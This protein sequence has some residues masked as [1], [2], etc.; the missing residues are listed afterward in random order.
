MDICICDITELDCIRLLS[1]ANPERIGIS[2]E[3]ALA[4]DIGKVGDALTCYIRSLGA[5][6]GDIHVAV[7]SP[8]ARRRK[9]GISCHV[10]SGG[11][12]PPDFIDLGQGVCGVPSETLYIQLCRRLSFIKR[13][14]LA[15]ELAGRYTIIPN[16]RY[17]EAEAGGANQP[18]TLSLE[19]APLTTVDRLRRTAEGH[20]NMHGAK[21]AREALRY[22]VDNAC[23]PAEACMAIAMTLPHNK[24][25][26][27][28][29]PM[30]MNHRVD[31][32]GHFRRCDA[33]LLVGGI[34][35]EYGSRAHHGSIE[36]MES[37]SIR[38][39]ELSSRGV[40]VV[41]ISSIE[42]RNPRLFHIVMKRVYRLQGRRLRITVEDFEARRDRLW[43]ELF[44]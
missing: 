30:I 21:L 13:I 29:G 18:P 2:R 11:S 4:A 23:S 44:S 26:Y 27:A 28:C 34:D 38:A 41:N 40:P 36:A 35:M 6:D 24:G 7:P 42:L 32:D 10:V 19:R 43:H 9:R 25:G 14:R 15:C 17:G 31:C 16:P 39:N 1:A 20:A 5:R 8:K 12:A 33:Y 3:R 37:D 22:A